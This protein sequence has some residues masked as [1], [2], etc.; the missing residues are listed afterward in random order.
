MKKCSHCGA[1]LNNNAL[2]CSQ[3]GYPADV[4]DNSP[5]GSYGDLGVKSSTYEEVSYNPPVNRVEY[6]PVSK[7]P[8][9]GDTAL[10]KTASVFLIISTV[11][12]AGIYLI[13]L[14]WCLPMTIKYRRKIRSG[15]IIST[16]FKVCTLIFVS[17]VAGILMLVDK[18]H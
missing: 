2:Y 17:L 10:S 3:C 15:E 14:I 12:L 18:D 7:Q 8:V 4:I 5:K 13:P 16:G 1:K 6:T 11:L 9:N